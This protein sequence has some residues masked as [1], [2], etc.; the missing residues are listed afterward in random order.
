LLR[1][2]DPGPASELVRTLETDGRRRFWHVAPQKA[3]G[4]DVPATKA[5]LYNSVDFQVP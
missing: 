3:H 1:A 5:A 4:S 2:V